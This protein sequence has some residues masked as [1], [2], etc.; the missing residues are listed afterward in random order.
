MSATL[1]S[2]LFESGTPQ[3]RRPLTA[4][5]RF[6]EWLREN[7]RIVDLF[8]RYAREAQAAGMRHY[9]VKAIAERVRWH[10]RVE[11]KGDEWKINNSFM[12]RLARELVRREPK[13][14]RI[15][16]FRKLKSSQ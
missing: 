12:S 3:I 8:L 15:F 6:E 14:G 5:D 16:E 9:G 10:V 13:L 11:M 1:Q 4:Q 2:R 7:P